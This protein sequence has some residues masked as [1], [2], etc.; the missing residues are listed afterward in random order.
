METTKNES[1]ETSLRQLRIIH[2]AMLF[3]IVLYA[4]ISLRAPARPAPPPTVLYAV[5][6]VALA[7]VGLILILR[8]KLLASS[9]PI[10]S[11]QSD[12]NVVIARWRSAYIITWAL[13]E[14]IA[15][16]GLVLRYMGFAM[17]QAM[18]FFGAGFVLM[19][20]FAPRRPFTSSPR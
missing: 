16:F 15:L 11:G 2:A 6:F 14:A 3:S 8:N 5:V 18:I 12:D 7:D 20:L 19:A 17:T 9:G 4:F 13:C 10:S 1:S